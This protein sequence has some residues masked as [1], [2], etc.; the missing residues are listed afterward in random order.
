MLPEAKQ[1][2]V[3]HGPPQTIPRGGNHVGEWIAAC[4]GVGKAFSNF[5]IGGAMTE[6]MQLIN[7][8]TLCEG[9]IEYDTVSGRIINSAS[10]NR[11]LHREYRQ[12]WS[13]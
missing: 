9:A 11:L 2:D 8:S 1:K 10:A 4:K 3:Q 7:L 12:G 5:D 6:L 13:I